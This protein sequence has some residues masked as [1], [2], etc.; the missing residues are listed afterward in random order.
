MNTD[1]HAERHDA[2]ASE[3][4]EAPRAVLDDQWFDEGAGEYAESDNH[5]DEVR[6]VRLD[7]DEKDV[8]GW[9][10]LILAASVGDVEAMQL[11]LENGADVNSSGYDQRTALHWASERGKETAVKLLVDRGAD[12]EAETY[13]WTASLLAAKNGHLDIMKLL[14][15]NGANVQA[16]D[17]HQ[18]T[19]LHWIAKYGSAA[20]VR[21]LADKGANV[22]A[23]D[24][25]GK[26][27]LM[28]AIENQ[29]T[30]TV[31][32][33]LEI[34][35]DVEAK[36]LHN[37]TALHMAVFLG[38]ESSVRNLLEQGANADAV[39]QWCEA[40]N[41]A[42][43]ECDAIAPVEK[44]SQKLI[45]HSRLVQVV[46]TEDGREGR[47]GLTVRQLAARGENVEIQRLLGLTGC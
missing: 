3:H 41:L 38:H 7:V 42:D 24:C 47:C 28:W 20:A 32:K 6:I 34:G 5:V 27:A 1:Q 35:A 13:R 37:V 18:R 19:T 23:S 33:L 2:V 43:F 36:A 26:T 16:D 17:Y 44:L 29:Q 39:A 31:R 14:V 30:E 22:N 10:A 4:G 12:I 8:G 40:E 21:L 11:L 46:P 9:T 25:W 45:H 15:E